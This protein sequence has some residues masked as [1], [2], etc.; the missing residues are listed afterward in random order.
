MA[1]PGSREPPV[2]DLGE[3]AWKTPRSSNRAAAVCP[4]IA[5]SEVVLVPAHCIAGTGWPPSRGGC[6]P[7]ATGGEQGL[8]VGEGALQLRAHLSLPC[9]FLHFRKGLASTSTRVRPAAPP[10]LPPLTP[11]RNWPAR[12][13]PAR[14]AQFCAVN[15]SSRVNPSGDC[16]AAA[17]RPRLGQ[18]FCRR[19]RWHAPTRPFHVPA[20][21][22]AEVPGGPT[23]RLPARL[24][25]SPSLSP[26]LTTGV[27][28]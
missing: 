6:R 20:V 22:G 14:L 24:L 1:G 13:I 11:P 28:A 17:P 10:N 7:R 27:T 12:S 19:T 18:R 4:R 21:G 2:P 23:S 15:P 5:P 3:V 16:G 9:P 25:G 26:Y 8:L